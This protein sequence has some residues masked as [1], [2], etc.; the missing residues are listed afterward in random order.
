MRFLLAV[1]ALVAASVVT[2]APDPGV[3][4][5]VKEAAQGSRDMVRA[6]R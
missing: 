6:Y 1:L 2:A 3:W 4:D 5:F